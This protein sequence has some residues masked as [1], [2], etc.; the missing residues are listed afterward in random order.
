M[1]GQIG[2]RAKQPDFAA[3][4]WDELAEN[5]ATDCFLY[6]GRTKETLRW[7][8]FLT[9]LDR[10]RRAV[11]YACT[12]DRVEQSGNLVFLQLDE[13]ETTGDALRQ[14]TTMTIFE[15]DAAG[16]LRRIDAFQ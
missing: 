12:V 4:G 10:W 16:R 2:Q 13:R 9:H 7:P 15:F 6:V 11:D 1:L 14:L 8:D 3:E 5:V